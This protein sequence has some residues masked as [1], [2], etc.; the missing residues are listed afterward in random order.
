[1]SNAANGSISIHFR[2]FP[3]LKIEATAAQAAYQVAQQALVA[4]VT[5]RCEAGQRVPMPSYPEPDDLL[6]NLPMALATKL[7]L[8]NEVLK[9]KRQPV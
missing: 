5:R 6:F 8:M 3:E 1:M 9:F 7:L 4:E 2:E